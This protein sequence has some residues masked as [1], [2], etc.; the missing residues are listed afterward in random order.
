MR[1]GTGILGILVLVAAM[2]LATRPAEGQQ[3]IKVGV[4]KP[5]TGP[6]AAVGAAVKQ[7]AEL[8]ADIINNEYDID[9]P[10]ARTRGIPSL[11]GAKIELVFGDTQGSP[12][13]GRAEAER[14]ITTQ[15]VVAILG[16]W[17]SGVTHTVSP[18]T[19]RY[20]IPLITQSTAPTLSQRGFKYFFRGGPN[21]P[22]AMKVMFEFLDEM[23]KQG[24]KIQRVGIIAED[25]ASGK[26]QSV[27]YERWSKERGWQVGGP[28]Y[29]SQNTTD[30]TSE[31]QKLKA[32][33]PDLVF[34][35]SYTQD[36]LLYV[37]EYRKQRFA[38]AAILTEGGPVDDARF[39][40]V[41]KADA[42]HFIAR[43]LWS[44]DLANRKP[45]AAKVNEL[46][47]KRTGRDLDANS[48]R[49]FAHAILL[50]EAIH[51]ARSAHPEE[52]QK[53]LVKAEIP[54]EQLPLAYGIKFDQNHDNQWAG[55][56]LGQTRD[57]RLCT[58][59]PAKYAACKLI[60]PFPK[61][62]TR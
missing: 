14:L 29:Y 62:E 20:K 60:W 55:A 51:R 19:E 48:S 52:I 31:V 23:V 49:I 27:V 56:M 6:V 3:P 54:E 53:A 47:R 46:F 18:V 38:P 40:E 57:G 9:M 41:A 50:A 26:D 61:W 2:A 37:R 44:V 59:Y 36:M 39:Y 5:L 11:G 25:T 13:V 1:R 34:Q 33:N 21:A 28:W 7:A 24:T 4:L 43:V 42:H 22:Q 12:E 58:I 45:L 8:A 15:N 16:A 30:V 10:M 35:T 32:A 17:H